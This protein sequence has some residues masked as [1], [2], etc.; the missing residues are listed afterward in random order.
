MKK[1]VMFLACFLTILFGLS[2]SAQAGGHL[3]IAVTSNLNTLDPAKSKIGDEYLYMF[4]VFNGLTFI[5]R[6]LTLKPD[7]AERWESS[8]DLKTWTFYLR[9][10]VKFHN[11]RELDAQDVVATIDH[12]MDK[13]T[14]SKARVNFLVVDKVE[15]VDKYTVRFHLNTPYAGFAD[16]FG[17]RQ[18]RIIPRDCIDTLA[19][20]PIGTGPFKF[21]SFLPGDRVELVRNP[22]Y[23]EKGL[24]LL[25]AV[26]LYV[27]PESAARV[28]ALEAGD[29]NV[30]WHLPLEAIDRL[31]KNPEIVVDEVPTSS[32]DGIILHNKMKPFDNPKVRQAIQLAIDKVE[33]AQIV[34]FGHGTPT[35]SPIPPSHPFY[36]SEIPFKTDLAKAKQLLAEAGYP[37]GFE[38]QMYVPEGRPA[39]ERLGLTAREML[40]PLGIKVNIQRVPWDK[41]ITDI[42]GKALCHTDGFYS[43]PT[44]DTS[45]YPWYYSRGSW[46]DD[47]WHYNNPK[48][49]KLLDLARKTKS[50]E[51]RKK[52]YMEFQRV[53]VEDPPGIIPYVINHVNAYRKE[54]KALHSSP[55]MYFDLR[56]VAITK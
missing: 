46:N 48:V 14:G 55:M 56:Q 2:W 13:A 29:V 26:T 41:F 15:V 20:H 44:V 1:S 24:P 36:N 4:A 40:K 18:A 7:L 11:G 19:T 9:K 35:H 33:M 30:V 51:E 21:V 12:I 8:D 45:L 34:L 22:D 3:K 17:E 23:F 39:R 38:F 43:R 54:I 5:D 49:D 37:N 27:I 10:G 53:V 6:D 50:N 31:K 28:T 25:D 42:E 32:W 16:L 52:I 47:T